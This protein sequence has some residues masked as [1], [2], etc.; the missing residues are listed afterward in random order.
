MIEDSFTILQ[1]G[2]EITLV[3]GDSDYVPA[4]EKLTKRGIK[5]H[6][7]FLATCRS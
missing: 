6:V 4:I 2:D 5:V 3:S 1:E 7:V